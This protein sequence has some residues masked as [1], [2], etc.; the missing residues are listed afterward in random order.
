MLPLHPSIADE[1]LSDDRYISGDE[2]QNVS[3][4]LVFLLFQL[5]NLT[6]FKH[7]AKLQ[8]GME[9]KPSLDQTSIN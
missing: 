5:L 1:G 4:R 3:V 2:K 6:W 7:D 8:V 9:R